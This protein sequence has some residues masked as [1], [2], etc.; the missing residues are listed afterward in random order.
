MTKNN[1]KVKNTKVKSKV[2]NN[3]NS[4]KTLSNT[5]TKKMKKTKKDVNTDNKI[6]KSNKIIK[7]KKED[8]KKKDE[9]KENN[10]ENKKVVTNDN[11][12]D[13][14]EDDENINLSNIHK[15]SGKIDFDKILEKCLKG[16]DLMSS[17]L[18]ANEKKKLNEEYDNSFGE[19]LKFRDN[20][21]KSDIESI[22]TIV[23]H[24]ENN[25]GMFAAAIAYHFYKELGKTN[26]TCVPIKPTKTER[27]NQRNQSELSRRHTSSVLWNI[28]HSNHGEVCP[29]LKLDLQC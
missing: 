25:D 19:I 4:K 9:K 27:L 28:H 12:N 14:D 21:T 26:I 11:E 17:S 22:D 5:K 8:E 2:L 20:M 16:K 10:K 15:E 24:N 23:Y 3:L 13:I 18:N 29:A 7:T 6:K 1:Y